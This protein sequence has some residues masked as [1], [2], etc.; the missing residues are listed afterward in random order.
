M[1]ADF[2]KYSSLEQTGGAESVVVETAKKGNET[3]IWV[4]RFVGSRAYL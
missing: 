3:R 2:T 1:R 4:S